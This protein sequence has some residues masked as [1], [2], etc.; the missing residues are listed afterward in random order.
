[1]RVK[2]ASE[3]H[4]KHHRRA[5]FD[6]RLQDPHLHHPLQHEERVDERLQD[7]RRHLPIC[8]EG[9]FRHQRRRQPRSLRIRFMLLVEGDLHHLGRHH[10]QVGVD[11]EEAEMKE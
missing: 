9:F 5:A 2:R 3:I 6:E 10:P 11:C 7:P 1:M 8:L 4:L